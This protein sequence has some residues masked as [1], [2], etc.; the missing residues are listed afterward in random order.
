MAATYLLW[1]LSIENHT[2]GWFPRDT[3]L[4]EKVL[5]IPTIFF[6]DLLKLVRIKPFRF[7]YRR[8]TYEVVP[9]YW[10]TLTLDLCPWEM[11]Q[12]FPFCPSSIMYYLQPQKVGVLVEQNK[13]CRAKSIFISF[14]YKMA[15][16]RIHSRSCPSSRTLL[17]TTSFQTKFYHNIPLI[18][19]RYYGIDSIMESWIVIGSIGTLVHSN[20]YFYG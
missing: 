19:N 11:N 5:P 10:L 2:N 18:W 3:L 9:T 15:D 17:S 13:L 16:V 4:I 20:L 1:F 7:L 8:Y 14:F 12:Y 6:F